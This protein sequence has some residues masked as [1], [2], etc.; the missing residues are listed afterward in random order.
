MYA[1]L[2][3]VVT[4]LAAWGGLLWGVAIN[5]PELGCIFAIAVMG[6]FIIGAIK[7]K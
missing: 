1:V 3:F 2:A 6:M 5:L 7:K 4:L